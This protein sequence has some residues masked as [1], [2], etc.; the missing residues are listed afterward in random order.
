MKSRQIAGLAFVGAVLV[1]TASCSDS[2]T[3]DSGGGD[4]TLT[5]GMWNKDQESTFREIAD[6][7]ERQHPEV[8]VEIELTP[9]GEY[10][11]KL[12]TAVQGGSAPDVFWMNGPQLPLYASNEIISPLDEVIEAQGIDLDSYPDSSMSLFEYEGN[13]YGLPQDA[14][15]VGLWYNKELFDA[16]ALDYPDATWTWED[17]QS[18]A[19]ALTDPANGVYGIA[20][21]LD[22]QSNYYNTVWQAGG[23][24]ISEDGE[25]S[26]W[27]SPENA[28]GI[29]FWTDLIDAGFSPTLGQLT[30]TPASQLFPSGKVAMHYSGTWNA[31]AYAED[32][33]L[34]QKI[35]VAPLPGGAE[36]AVAVNSLTSVVNAASDSPEKAAE[37]AAFVASEEAAD[38]RIAA[39]DKA[40]AYGE[41]WRE[42]AAD[43]PFQIETVMEYSL[44]H[45]RPLPSTLNTAEWTAAEVDTLTQI[46]AG[47]LELEAGLQ[48]LASTVDALLAEGGR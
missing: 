13:Q 36:A 39:Q 34:A 16:K 47:Q 17:V 8:T 6:E 33:A 23:E 43:S 46:Y 31:G 37:F 44:E 41:K 19:A 11:T 27:A 7:F 2:S 21:S 28:I 12:Q 15:A 30:E 1:V 26:G 25:S 18:A 38:I 24:I 4:V 3:S 32:D 29:K 10:W 42:W 9:V 48:Q 14:D 40:P 20:S 22:S 5:F 35:D 45:G